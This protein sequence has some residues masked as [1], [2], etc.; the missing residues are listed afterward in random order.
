MESKPSVLSQAMDYTRNP[1]I[2]AVYAI[3]EDFKECIVQIR[4]MGCLVNIKGS[5]ILQLM[6]CSGVLDGVAGQSLDLV[7]DRFTSH[8]LSNDVEV[9]RLKYRTD[10]KVGSFRFVPVEN[11][12]EKPDNWPS[13]TLRVPEEVTKDFKVITFFGNQR[14]TLDLTYNKSVDQHQV[15]CKIPY[16]VEKTSVQG[17][18]IIDEQNGVVGLLQWSDDEK[19]FIPIFLK[20]NILTELGKC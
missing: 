20:E 1:N 7:M 8:L 19:K 18:P 4:G 3:R 10:K 15:V 6:T 17:A 5:K 13:L 2:K 12:F 11:S 14:L 16:I 9:Y